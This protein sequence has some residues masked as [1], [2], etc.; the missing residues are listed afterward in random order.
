MR[1]LVP[2][3]SLNRLKMDGI[4]RTNESERGWYGEESVDGDFCPADGDEE[5][6][7]CALAYVFLGRPVFCVDQDDRG[8][9]GYSAESDNC[10]H[11]H[12]EKSIP[13]GSVIKLD[14]VPFECG[15]HP[16]CEFED[17]IVCGDY[18]AWVVDRKNVVHDYP[19]EQ[20][21]VGLFAT[22]DIVRRPW[23]VSLVSVALP[24]VMSGVESDPIL[25]SHGVGKDNCKYS[26]K[27]LLGFISG[28]EFPQWMCYRRAEILRDSNPNEYSLVLGSLGYR[29]PDGSIV[30]LYG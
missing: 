29:Q 21:Q 26:S 30:W 4:D 27:Q 17:S 16:K 1:N 12:V 15:S 18:H 19:T 6:V 28:G 14:P 5:N 23:D 7:M 11:Q 25:I 20:L 13:I 2:C 3:S 24:K 9:E 8:D 22:D 10:E